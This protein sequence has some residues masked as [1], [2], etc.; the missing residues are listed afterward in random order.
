[1]KTYEELIENDLKVLRNFNNYICD[2]KLIMEYKNI[3]K[4]IP[5][6][7]S[8]LVTLSY[9]DFAE[10][11][12]WTT[13]TNILID[14]YPS[15]DNKDIKKIVLYRIYEQLDILY[16]ASCN[17]IRNIEEYKKGDLNG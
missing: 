8:D 2:L 13:I 9:Y 6:I 5:T 17:V 12:K 15:I 1:M 11:L 4:S 7:K 3:I 10:I 14:E 16:D